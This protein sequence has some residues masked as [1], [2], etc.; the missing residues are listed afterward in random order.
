M[1]LSI[2][3]EVLKR[4]YH[5]WKN[6]EY[7]MLSYIHAKSITDFRSQVNCLVMITSPAL[8]QVIAVLPLLSLIKESD[9]VFHTQTW[10]LSLLMGVDSFRTDCPLGLDI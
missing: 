3:S 7:Q 6:K 8:H 10:W 1:W 4:K 5:S 2:V 9:C